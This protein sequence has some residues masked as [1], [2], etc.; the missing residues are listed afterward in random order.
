M[1]LEGKGWGEVWT[2][3]CGI[4]EVP[5]RV[6]RSPS[7]GEKGRMGLEERGP[8]MAWRSEWTVPRELVSV[9]LVF[10][11]LTLR[12]VKELRFCSGSVSGAWRRR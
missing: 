8:G 1:L 11:W 7:D 12:T 5:A 9:G 2:D 3:C 4:V 6:V 10:G